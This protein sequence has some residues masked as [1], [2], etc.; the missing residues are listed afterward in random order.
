MTNSCVMTDVIDRDNAI[1]YPPRNSDYN[2]II[3][4]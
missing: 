1:L 2:F 4:V 3:A